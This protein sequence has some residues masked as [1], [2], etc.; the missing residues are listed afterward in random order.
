M[1]R[2]KDLMPKIGDNILVRA[3]ALNV[4]QG[5]ST[6]FFIK[7]GQR[8]AT[9]LADIN[10]GGKNA[11]DVPG[12]LKDILGKDSLDIFLNT[13]PHDDHL[14]GIEALDE[15]VGFK[16]VMMA[17]YDPGNDTN[18]Y[19]KV[20]AKIVDRM[21]KANKDSVIEVDGSYKLLPLFDASL[22]I[23]APAEYVLDDTAEKTKTE[24]RALIHENCVVFKVGKD[25]SW[26]IQLGDAD[27]DA[28]KKHIYGAHKKDLSSNVL[29]APHHGSK[30]FF[31]EKDKCD[32]E[33][34]WLAPLEAINPSAVIVSAP[35]RCE[36]RF[37][38]PDE[39]AMDIYAKKVGNEKVFHTGKSRCSYIVDI[40]EDGSVSR[41]YSDEGGLMQDYQIGKDDDPPFVAPTTANGDKKPRQFG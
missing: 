21:R 26:V 4:G 5:D 10:M 25:S 15:K 38:H 3:V 27:Y 29:F 19:Y 34:P 39:E 22:H 7:D 36:S 28:F 20:F 37:E 40:Y 6:L 31:W 35:R 1:I 8:Y 23:L 32:T 41:V 18:E 13:H 33:E 17:D 11:I 9:M 24:R 12:L 16:V 2:A 14:R 30:Y